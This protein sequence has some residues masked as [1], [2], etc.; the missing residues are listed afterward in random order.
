MSSPA[1]VVAFYGISS[2][3]DAMR[4]FCSAL[5]AWMAGLGHPTNRVT[6]HKAGRRK[7][8]EYRTTDTI[9]KEG[10]RDTVALTLAALPE[11]AEIPMRDYSI[12][13]C[14]SVDGSFAFVAVRTS[15]AT[16]SQDELL[17][18]ARQLVGF[19]QPAY[20]TGYVGNSSYA[21]GINEGSEDDEFSGPRYEEKLTVSRWGDMGMIEEVYRQGIVRDIYPWNFLSSVHLERPVSGTTLGEWIREDRARGSLERIRE[22]AWFWEVASEN[23][24]AIKGALRDTGV[25]FDWR[26]LVSKAE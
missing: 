22:G 13:A 7:K 8:A 20:G 18:M 12:E 15:I 23:L 21:I 16:L 6:V 14:C 17:P 3:A 9:M 19:L 26:Q 11:G 5:T 24:A 1:A 10:F 2:D 25:I 4:E